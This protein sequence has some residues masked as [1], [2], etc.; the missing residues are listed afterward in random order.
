MSTCRPADLLEDDHFSTMVR[1]QSTS[2]CPNSFWGTHMHEIYSAN[3]SQTA[4]FTTSAIYPSMS[5]VIEANTVP[6]KGK[7]QQTDLHV[8]PK[9]KAAQ[10]AKSKVYKEY[11]I[12]A[13]VTALA[14]ESPSLQQLQSASALAEEL[15]C[16]LRNRIRE[17]TIDAE[18][19]AIAKQVDV[20]LTVLFQDIVDAVADYG[21]AKA[22]AEAMLSNI[23]DNIRDDYK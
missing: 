22:V 14:L 20:T 4:Y 19:L 3:Q 1:D 23:K 18:T 16:E 10:K 8:A 15:A 17:K 5:S 21:T 11:G 13:I 12:K 9:S 7:K 2:V 6:K